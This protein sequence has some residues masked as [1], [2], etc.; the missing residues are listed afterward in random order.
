VEEIH[1]G[2]P[3]RGQ[4]GAQGL[5]RMSQHDRSD[6]VDAPVQAQRSAWG[7]RTTLWRSSRFHKTLRS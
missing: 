5:S 2:R 7:A 1:R 3:R 4:P 6:A